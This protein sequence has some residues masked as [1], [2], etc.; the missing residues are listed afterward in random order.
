[1]TDSTAPA[2]TPPADGAAAAAAPAAPWYGADAPADVVEFVT[3]GGIDSP[4]KAL[5]ALREAQAAAGEA[6]TLPKDANDKA[7]WDAFYARLG[8]PENADGYELPVPDGDSGE[9]A[10][11]LAPA[12]HEAGVTKAQAAKLATAFNQIVAGRAQ[13]LDQAAAAEAAKQETTLK[14]EWGAQYGSNVDLAKRAA[15]AFGVDAAKVSALEQVIGYAE[16]MKFFAAIGK[17]LGEDSFVPGTK[18]NGHQAK[19]LA[20]KLYPTMS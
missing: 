19:S 11:A 14:T 13:A 1:M 7:A 15:A 17:K 20:E 12:L 5:T 3:K 8:R 16:T 2:S 10:K 4:L 6:L 9:F 18:H